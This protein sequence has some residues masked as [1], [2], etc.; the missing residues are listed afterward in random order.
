MIFVEGNKK[1]PAEIF[2]GLLD[3]FLKPYGKLV[4]L[5][6]FKCGPGLSDT[7]R[8]TF[9][10]ALLLPCL[11]LLAGQSQR[12]AEFQPL[13]DQYLEGRAIVGFDSTCREPMNSIHL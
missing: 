8:L 6:D 5:E 4:L 7:V 9:K 2:E 3:R 13:L 11:H 12:A 10:R 1:P